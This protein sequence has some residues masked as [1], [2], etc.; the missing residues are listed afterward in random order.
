MQGLTNL[1]SIVRGTK[2]KFWCTVVTGTDIR[3]VRLIGNE[4]LGTSEITEL[5]DAAVGVEKEVLRLDV[6]VTDALRVDV[7]QGS[8]KLVNVK[9]DLKDGHGGLHLVEKSRSS[10][11]GLGH[12]FLDK[13]KVNLIFL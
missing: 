8:E 4:N 13:V 6:S 1:G 12:E 9:L 7:G 2:D 11:N 10:V 5:E 3:N